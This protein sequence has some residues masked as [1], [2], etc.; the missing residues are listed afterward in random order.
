M[1]LT[2]YSCDFNNIEALWSTVKI[3]LKSVSRDVTL[4]IDDAVTAI[5]NI[6]DKVP[7]Y[8]LLAL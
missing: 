7:I 8:T 3:Q 1:Y 4:K 6:M 2:D 5:K